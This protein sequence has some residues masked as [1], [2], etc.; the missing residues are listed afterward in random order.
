PQHRA[1]PLGIGDTAGEIARLVADARE[2]AEN[3]RGCGAGRLHAT[4]KVFVMLNEIVE[5]PERVLARDLRAEA[6]SGLTGVTFEGGDGGVLVL[7]FA[8][9]RAKRPVGDVPG[10]GA[11]KLTSTEMPG[12]IIRPS[13]DRRHASLAVGPVEMVSEL[14][15]CTNNLAGQVVFGRGGIL[16]HNPET[17]DAATGTCRPRQALKDRDGA[18]DRRDCHP[19]L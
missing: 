15:Q 4:L 17:I 1:Q 11:A 18:A 3:T 19:R 5:L 13:R 14:V 2:L 6:R 8:R 7:D 16:E 10:D 12:L 9:D